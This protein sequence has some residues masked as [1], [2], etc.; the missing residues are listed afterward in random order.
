MSRKRFSEMNCA[1]AQALDQIGDWWTLLIVRDAFNGS[2]TFS[3]FQEGLGIAKN[4][5]TERLGALVANGIMAREQT[6]PHV[7]RYTYHLTKKGESLM[8][9]LIALIQW[10][11][12]WAFGGEGPLR[13]LDA[14]EKKAIRP[15]TVQAADGRALSY[16][17]LRYRPGPGATEETLAQF[18]SK[19]KRVG[20]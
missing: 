18:A 1:A 6:R 12:Q 11:D 13:I 7:N 2:T 10:G 17:E 19:A 16:T 5:L 14:K 15:V 3:E 20:A 8:P 4:I 9:I